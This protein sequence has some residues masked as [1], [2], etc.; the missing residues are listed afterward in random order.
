MRNII[1]L[2]AVILFLIGCQNS[3]QYESKT[4]SN[5]TA[6]PNIIKKEN[7]KNTSDK[8]NIIKK[9]NLNNVSNSIIN[10][11]ILSEI[12]GNSFI[13]STG[14]I[15]WNPNKNESKIFPIWLDEK[16]HST[17]DTIMFFDDSRNRKCAIVIFSTYNYYVKSQSTNNTD[18]LDKGD[19]HFCG[20]KIGVAILNQ[21]ENKNWIV[22][23]S[24]KHL[25]DLGYF[26]EYKNQGEEKCK[27]YLKK[28]GDNWN[29]LC[30]KQGTGGNTGG[31]SGYESFYSIEEY[32]L[33]S[34]KNNLFTKIFEY[35]YLDYFE[36]QITQKITRDLKAK[37]KLIENKNSYY[38]ID[39]AKTNFNKTKIEHYKYSEE[40]GKYILK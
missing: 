26:G 38:D 29:C 3:S 39:L 34:T 10:K 5:D 37:L 1:T 16:C 12:F 11:S 7:L 18:I 30:L 24:K 35:Y 20:A 23:K 14:M 40:Q 36:N 4:V 17:I 33:D 2:I 9:E 8:Q 15:L 6:E 22:I 28:I 19:C 13:D 21:I 25:A 31:W 27:I 32:K